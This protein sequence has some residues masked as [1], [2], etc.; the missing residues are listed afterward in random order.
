[1]LDTIITIMVL[2]IV[3]PLICV[4]AVILEQENL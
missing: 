4:V 3:L 1:M 2:I